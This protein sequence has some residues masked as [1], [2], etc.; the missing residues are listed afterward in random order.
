MDGIT[1]FL[2]CKTPALCRVTHQTAFLIPAFLVSDRAQP[3][4]APG[5]PD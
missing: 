5:E 3:E 1:Y 2:S 4:P